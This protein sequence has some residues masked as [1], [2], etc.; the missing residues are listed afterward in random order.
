MVNRIILN[1]TS[2]FGR[3][4]RNKLVDELKS[5]RIEK[6]LVVTDYNLIQNNIGHYVSAFVIDFLN[7]SVKYQ[8]TAYTHS[9]IDQ[10][11]K[12]D[13]TRKRLYMNTKFFL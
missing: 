12:Y 13:N 11:R 9:D 1:E 2:Y 4:S 6:V 8:R 10:Q 7:C 5:R 3:G